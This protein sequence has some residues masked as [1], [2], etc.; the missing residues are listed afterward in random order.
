MV[1][2]YPYRGS[3][4]DIIRTDSSLASDEFTRVLDDKR[5][6]DDASNE[7]SSGARELG[8]GLDTFA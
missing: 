1:G 6:L 8:R 7:K 3:F 2:F 5:E 4:A